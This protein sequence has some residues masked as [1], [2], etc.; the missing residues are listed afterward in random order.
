MKQEL[1]IKTFS[2]TFKINLRIKD[3]KMKTMT[4][5]HKNIKWMNKIKWYNKNFRFIH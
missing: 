2:S 4:M 5:N 3:T 1:R